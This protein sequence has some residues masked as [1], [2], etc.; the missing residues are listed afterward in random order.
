MLLSTKNI[1]KNPLTHHISSEISRN[2]SSFSLFFPASLLYSLPPFLFPP[3]LL[4]LFSFPFLFSNKCLVWKAAVF[5]ALPPELYTNGLF[6]L[7][8][9]QSS[10]IICGWY[11]SYV[12]LIY[13]SLLS[14]FPLQSIFEE[15]ALFTWSNFPEVFI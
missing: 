13:K 10:F 3:F 2:E 1:N 5:T 8:S 14:F 12:F 6:E 11:S 9:K 4:F 15:I 7:E